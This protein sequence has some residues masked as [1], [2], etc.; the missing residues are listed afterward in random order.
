[1][2][3]AEASL[4]HLLEHELRCAERYRRFV[5]VMRAVS[6]LDGEPLANCLADSMRECDDCV[7]LGNGFELLMTE[8]TEGGALSAAQRY[9]TALRGKANLAFGIAEFPGDGH[10]AK[11]LLDLAQSRLERSVRNGCRNM[12]VKG[13]E[14]QSAR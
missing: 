11:N 6:S 4:Q 1:M 13:R 14:P 2:N 3:E 5:S 12:S 8:T 10:D 9:A 7:W